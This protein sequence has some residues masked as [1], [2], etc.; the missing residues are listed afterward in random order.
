MQP[1]LYD[2]PLE[3]LRR[4]KYEG[5]RQKETLRINAFAQRLCKERNFIKLLRIYFSPYL[6][7]GA[8]LPYGREKLQG[9]FPFGQTSEA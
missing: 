5:R 1:L 3:R 2:S 6:K 8:V 9:G 4:H 7:A